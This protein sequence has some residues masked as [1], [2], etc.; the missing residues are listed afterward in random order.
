VVDYRLLVLVMSTI[1]ALCGAYL[2]TRGPEPVAAEEPEA[3]AA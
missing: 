1:T 3:V 2:L